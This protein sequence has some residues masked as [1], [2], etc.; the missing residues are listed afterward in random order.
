MQDVKAWLLAE[1]LGMGRDS[2]NGALNLL[3]DRGYLIDHGRG[4]NKVRRLTVAIIREG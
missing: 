3:V 4:Q 1:Q 2:V